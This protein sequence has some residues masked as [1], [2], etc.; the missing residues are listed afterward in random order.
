MTD[1]NNKEEVLEAV[2]EDGSRLER[3]SKELKADKEVVLEAVKNSG[4]LLE[5]ASE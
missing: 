5:Y 1:W 3:A 2:R 4:Y